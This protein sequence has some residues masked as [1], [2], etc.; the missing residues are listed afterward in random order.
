MPILFRAQCANPQCAGTELFQFNIVNSMTADGL[1]PCIARTSAPMILTICRISKFLSYK[2]KISIAFMHS[3]WKNDI[4]CKY[5]LMFL[6]KNLPCKK[7]NSLRP[8][9]AIWRHR[10]G[11]TLAQVMACCLTAPSHYLNT[12]S[13]HLKAIL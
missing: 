2:R 5:M 8:I 9:D 3:L 11:S 1:A 10:S 7:V 13:I 12:S 4:V 6:L